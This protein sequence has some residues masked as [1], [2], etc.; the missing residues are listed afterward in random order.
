MVVYRTNPYG[1]HKK[2]K[3]RRRRKRKRKKKMCS[4]CVSITS[5]ISLLDMV[6][7]LYGKTYSWHDIKEIK[8]VDKKKNP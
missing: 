8:Y 3:K 6:L 2:P 5:I 7:V 1:L 4:R